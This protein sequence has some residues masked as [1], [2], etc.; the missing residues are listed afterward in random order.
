MRPR[1]K[2]SDVAAAAGVSSTAASF[3]FNRPDRLSEETL[4][5]VL[6]AAA[7]LG[8]SRDPIGRMLRQGRTHS[9]GVLLPQDVPAVM[10]NPYYAQFLAGV[11]TTCQRE[12]LTILLVPPL[13]GSMLKALP[14]AAADG[15]V[16][17]GLE[18]DRGE[19][20][21][22]NQRGVPM[23]LVDSEPLP[24]LSSVE[25]DD[26][27]GAR[28]VCEFLLGQGH[29]RIGVVAFESG[30]PSNAPHGV[31]RY[32]GPLA[33]RLEGIAEALAREGLSLDSPGIS[34]VEAPCHRRGGHRAFQQLWGRTPR[35]TAILALSDVLAMGVLDAAREAGVAVPDMISVTG[36]D[37]Q[38][39]AGSMVPAL[40]TVRQEAET[41][42]RL[43]ADLLVESIHSRLD[44][45]QQRRLPATLVV[46]DSTAPVPNGDE[47]GTRSRGGAG[48]MVRRSQR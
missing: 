27:G 28:A 33:R 1:V 24:D 34:V 17:C 38:P 47:P 15:F 16:V 3:A 19:I 42:G 25:V 43:A 31:P 6:R 39:D 13:R 45:A 35:P 12:G 5:R 8:Y 41:K 20:T 36:F 46:R 30:I 22:L 44:R 29:R 48:R 37:D 9:L 10:A 23:V 21:T 18:A 32:R 26:R 14:Y 2:L 40:T 7:D 4:R 11:G